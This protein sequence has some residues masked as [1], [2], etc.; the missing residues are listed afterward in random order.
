MDL[1]LP[2]QGTKRDTPVDFAD[3]VVHCRAPAEPPPPPP[4]P[5]PVDPPLPPPVKP[6]PPPILVPQFQPPPVQ[7]P[8]ANIN[9]NAGFSQ[10]E[11]QQFQLAAVTQDAAQ[12]QD[13]EEIELAM[14]GL[15]RND[16][17]AAQLVFG[18]AAGL[19]VAAGVV[20]ANRRRVQR[21]IRPSYVRAGR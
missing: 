9:P 14:S 13:M 4:P 10:Q 17:A 16:A 19:S 8:P 20:L 12:D 18:C 15:D 2:L 3:I 21:A 11:E 5:P 6:P 7:Q 1:P